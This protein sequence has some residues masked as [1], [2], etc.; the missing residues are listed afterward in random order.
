MNLRAAFLCLLVAGCSH[1]EPAAAPIVQP[2]APAAISNVSEVPIVAHLA[3]RGSHAE[4]CDAI[5]DHVASLLCEDYIESNGLKFEAIEVEAFIRTQWQQ[6]LIADGVLARFNAL[7]AN[8]FTPPFRACEL[9]AA[10]LYD[11]AKCLNAARN[12]RAK[13]KL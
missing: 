10:S 6:E 9:H 11:A 5:R 1:T 4:E 12:T 7:C 13:V 2:A 8:V 3:P